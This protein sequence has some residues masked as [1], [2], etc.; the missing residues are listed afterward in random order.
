MPLVSILILRSSVGLIT[1]EEARLQVETVMQ[2]TSMKCSVDQLPLKP[3][4]WQFDKVRVG[5]FS[6]ASEAN[7]TDITANIQLTMYK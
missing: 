7:R 3:T 5:V 6:S 2:T 4:V 1:E